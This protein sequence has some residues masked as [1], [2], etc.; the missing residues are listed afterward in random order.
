MQ[1]VEHSIKTVFSQMSTLQIFL[2]S[3]EELKIK[4]TKAKWQINI[5]CDTNV[6]SVMV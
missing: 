4:E 5:I 6:D 2:K 1:N 3:K